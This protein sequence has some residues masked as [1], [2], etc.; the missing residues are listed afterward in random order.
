LGG[1]KGFGDIRRST[2]ISRS[3]DGPF[4]YIG[5]W[6]TDDKTNKIRKGLYDYGSYANPGTYGLTPSTTYFVKSRL[7]KTKNEA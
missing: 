2:Y 6:S 7:S 5:Y 4:V 1:D 3:A